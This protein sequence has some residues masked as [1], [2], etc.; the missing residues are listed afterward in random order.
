ME[1]DDDRGS[2]EKFDLS[3]R[4]FWDFLDFFV[5]KNGLSLEAEGG[6]STTYSEAKMEGNVSN[7][8]RQ[9]TEAAA[10]IEL[11]KTFGWR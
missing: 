8:K 3:N 1:L 4:L 2:S 7:T 10:K 11:G 9:A 5:V 6:G